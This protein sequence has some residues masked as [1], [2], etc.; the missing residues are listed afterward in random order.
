MPVSLR[1]RSSEGVLACI[2]NKSKCLSEFGIRININVNNRT[3]DLIDRGLLCELP[4]L[5]YKN[6]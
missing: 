2:V 6:S 4:F 1:D 3:K 5:A